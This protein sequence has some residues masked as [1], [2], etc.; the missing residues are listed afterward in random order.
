MKR[1]L[2]L[3]GSLD[4]GGTEK[5]LFNILKYIDKSFDIHI[6]LIEKRG[7][8]YEDFN[9]LNITIHHAFEDSKKNS[10]VILHIFKFTKNL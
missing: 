2:I 6:C 5:Q 1:I 3:I 10:E 4:I 9:K 7:T 8:M